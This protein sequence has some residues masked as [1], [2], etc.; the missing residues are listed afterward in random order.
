M[1]SV[2][3]TLNRVTYME[4]NNQ[5]SV[6]TPN[7]WNTWKH[8][9][10]V[11]LMH[12]GCWQFIIQT[13]PEQPDE[14]ATYKEKLDLQLRKD[15]CYTLI[16]TNISSD[17][18][19][20]ITET[21]DGV[22]TWKILKDH[23]EPVTKA[24]VIQLLDQFFGTKYQPGGD[25]GIFI[26]R[27]K[28]A[29]TRLQE[30]GHKLDDLYIGFQLIRWLPQEFQSTV[31]QI[32]RWKEEDFR[33]VKIEAELI[34]EANRLQL[35]KQDL[36]KA[37]NAYL[38][39]F[40]LK[41]SKTL[42]GTTAAAHGDPNGKNDYQKKG[43]LKPITNMKMSLATED[44]SCP[45]EGIGTL[46]F[47][48]KYKGSFHEITLTDVLFNPKLR[49]NLLSGPRLESKGAHFVGTKGSIEIWHQ[50]FCHVNNDYLVKT[51]KID[52]IKGLPRLTDNGKTHC[53]PCKLAK[54][55]RVSF[56]KT[57]AVRSKRPLELLHMDLC[58]PMPTESQGGNKYF[59]SIIDD[60]SR[61]VTVFPIRNKSDV[62]HTFIRFQ[63]RA[64]RFLSK[65]VIAIRTDGGL[66]FCNKD[67]DNFLTELG[68]KH[69]VTNSYTPE[70]NG[71]AE[72]FNLTALDSIKTL[73][74]SSEVPHKF[75]GE[76]LLCF[77]YAWNRICQKDSN[78]TP[79]EKYS[80]RKPSVLHLKPF[81]CLAYAGVPKQIR[82]KFDMRAKMGIMMGYAQRTKGYRIWLIDENN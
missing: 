65:K 69:V 36:E 29:A 16:Y 13:K 58:G 6:L 1:N 12:Y 53:I 11:L 8:D 57:G 64:E 35:M 20:L 77:T 9:M 17:L 21:T 79:F 32:Y 74:K 54:S 47:R 38:R 59:L 39:S 7:N 19:N 42:P 78:K 82:K 52:R 45:V 23:F 76:A 66:E 51:S 10:Q 4:F 41:K 62:F 68:I 25:V 24:K 70:M 67:I 26:S 3:S 60:Y 81:G 27:V 28:T 43:D 44:K 5:I 33:V 22:T 30:A 46:R 49:R 55:K 50:R 63:K 34:L 71:V 61:K 14:E 75:W 18:K 40:T 72:R 2:A 31:Q 56:K 37:E 80:G 15:R 48:V 73:L